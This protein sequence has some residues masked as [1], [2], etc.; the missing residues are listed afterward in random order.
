MTEREIL[1]RLLEKHVPKNPEEFVAVITK[2]NA[3]K[4]RMLAISELEKIRVD[5]R[6]EYQATCKKISDALK[7]LQSACIHDF[8]KYV[9]TGVTC[10]QCVIC[11]LII[12]AR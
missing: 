1:L 11:G 3:I 7:E 4:N 9:P 2:A 8:K 12:E 10:H 5:C 6:D